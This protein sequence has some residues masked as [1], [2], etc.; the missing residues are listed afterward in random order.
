MSAHGPVSPITLSQEKND[1]HTAS[2]LVNLGTTGTSRPSSSIGLDS[3]NTA[4]TL[5][6]AVQTEAS[7]KYRPTHIR[8]PNPKVMFCVSSGLSVPS[9][10]RKRSGRN[11]NGRGYLDSL[12]AIDLWG[13]SVLGSRWMGKRTDQR[14]E[15]MSVPEPSQL[16]LSCTHA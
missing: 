13:E 7:A 10:F 11:S 2:P 4:K 14:F 3:V 9:S 8:R 16:R 1:T 12:C 6:I 5:A 15:M